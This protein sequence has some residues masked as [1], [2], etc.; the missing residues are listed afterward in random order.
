MAAGNATR[1]TFPM[2][3][4]GKSA[5]PLCFS[6]VKRFPCH[7]RSQKYSWMDRVLLTEI[8]EEVDRKFASQDKKITLI[9]DNCP[10]NPKVDGLKALELNFLPPKTTSKTQPMDQ[11][12]ITSLKATYCRSLNISPY[13]V[14]MRENT[15]QNNSNTDTFYT[16]LSAISQALIEEGRLQTSICWRQLLCLLQLG[17]VFYKKLWSTVSRKS[18]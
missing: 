16:V 5:K 7:Y 18:V 8:M 14:R 10:A 1:E 12:V 4:I 2:F 9:M 15:D 13:S 6:G 17:N 3:V 11:S